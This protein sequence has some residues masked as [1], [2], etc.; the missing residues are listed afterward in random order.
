MLSRDEVEV[1]DMQEKSKRRLQGYDILRI[2]LGIILIVAACLKAFQLATEPSLVIGTGWTNELLSSRWFKIV[3]ME[4]ELGFGIW[5]LT[6]LHKALTRKLAFG[7]FTCFALVAL[8]K[9]V[10]G[11]A[12]CGCFG[13]LEVDPWYT[14][15][16]D[17]AVICLLV[18]CRPACMVNALKSKGQLLIGVVAVICY[19]I[20]GSAMVYTAHKYEPRAVAENGLIFADENFVILEPENWEGKAFPLI[21]YIDIGELLETGSWLIV[22]YKHDCPHCLE[23]IPKYI[24]KA[25]EWEHES[26]KPKIALIETE[27]SEDMIKN[28]AIKKLYYGKLTHQYEWFVQTPTVFHINNNICSIR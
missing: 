13:K 22:L 27:P 6:G 23:A 8:Y 3:E 5:L 10:D 24:Q 2:A 26:S 15:G 17:V 11:A 28:K 20:A 14:L 7:L 1:L 21:P 9:V 16:L 25:K 18:F 19:L 4:L 12:S